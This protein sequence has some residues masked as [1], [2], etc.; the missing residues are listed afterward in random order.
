MRTGAAKVTTLAMQK[1]T[2]FRFPITSSLL[3]LAKVSRAQDT[4][5][6]SLPTSCSL[7]VHYRHRI[8]PFFHP[9]LLRTSQVFAQLN[10]PSSSQNWTQLSLMQKTHQRQKQHD[11]QDSPHI[12]L[13][14]HLLKMSARRSTREPLEI[15]IS[16][17]Q[18]AGFLRFPNLRRVCRQ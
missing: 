9:V 7:N 10:Q 17:P 2:I 16:A 18:M 5:F 3:V 15:T 1:H 11:I 8:I 14:L 13:L 6:T 12:S 4:H